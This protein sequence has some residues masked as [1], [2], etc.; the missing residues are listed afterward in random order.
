MSCAHTEKRSTTSLT[1]GRESGF[2]ERKAKRSGS[3]SRCWSSG[4]PDR[5]RPT[6]S[7]HPR[8][9][10]RCSRPPRGAGDPPQG[11]G[12]N[13]SP[14]SRKRGFCRVAYKRRGAA[15]TTAPQGGPFLIVMAL[16]GV[17]EDTR[18]RLVGVG[19]RHNIVERSSIS[20]PAEDHARLA[21][22]GKAMASTGAYGF[23]EK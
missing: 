15:K 3:Q 8:S 14:E 20:L 19:N 6:G 4:L 23:G 12:T 5:A 11:D 1:V 16:G 22:A 21:D 13:P 17:A 18:K 10:W 2:E 7:A 9:A